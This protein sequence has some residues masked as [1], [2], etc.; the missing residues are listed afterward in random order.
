MNKFL[1][2]LLFT[3]GANISKAA[4]YSSTASITTNTGSGTAW[5]STANAIGSDNNRANA[6]LNSGGS[7]QTLVLTGFGF[8]IPANE[9]IT[10]IEV[11]VEKSMNRFFAPVSDS[12]VSLTLAGTASS[13]N[14]AAGGWSF[15]EGISLYS[16]GSLAWGTS[17]S[18]A[19]INSATFGVRIGA[20]MGLYF[21]SANVRIDN[22]TITVT[23]TPSV[24]P[25]ELNFFEATTS[26]EAVDL[27][28]TTGSE[29]NNDYFEVQKSIN[30][31]DFETIEVITGQGSTVLTTDYSFTDYTP[32]N[33][34]NYYR[35]MQVDFDG[36]STY[37]SIQIAK[38]TTATTFKAYPN[39]ATNHLVIANMPQETVNYIKIFNNYGQ[40]VIEKVAN[41][42]FINLSVSHLKAGSYIIAVNSNSNTLTEKL[43]IQ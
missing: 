29:I 36:T 34:T 32:N 11:S 2:L 38:I 8:A 41:T 30:G 5:A 14:L 37:S 27:N 17:Y 39:P 26:S 4:V 24:L 43:I 1:A 16:S 6:T 22:V 35:L 9:E 18:V 3:I 28:W 33:G 21:F 15:F 20:Q 40:V 12:E 25:V 13:N 19:D 42:S 7:T 23:T 31:T 10:A